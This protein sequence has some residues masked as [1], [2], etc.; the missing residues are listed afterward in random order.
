[1][2]RRKFITLS[3]ASCCSMFL[4]NCSTNPV[5]DRKQLLIYPETFINKQ[6][7]VFYNNFIRR[8]KISED[9]KNIKLISGVLM[10]NPFRISTGKKKGNIDFN[11][12]LPDSTKFFDHL[13]FDNTDNDIALVFDFRYVFSVP[14]KIFI[15]K[16]DNIKIFNKEL[17]SEMQVEYSSYSSRLGITQI[18]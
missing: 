6:S 4:P 1:M 18:I 2:N 7:A 10:K 12:S 16:F 8:S 9:K 13:H 5:T 3:A 14:E 11:G 15:D 17:L